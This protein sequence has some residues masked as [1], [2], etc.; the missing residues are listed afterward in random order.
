[1]L[2]LANKLNDDKV[3]VLVW[4]SK[5]LLKEISE[6]I[7]EI[8]RTNNIQE[9]VG[10]YFSAGVLLKPSMEDNFLTTN[11]IVF[12]WET[13][14]VNYD[15]GGSSEGVDVD[16]GFVIDQGCVNRVTDVYMN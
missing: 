14:V 4:L 10:I 12:I 2:Q 6:R 11:Q 15:T 5:N 9:L 7:I 13:P 1:M 16:I 8:T 3:I